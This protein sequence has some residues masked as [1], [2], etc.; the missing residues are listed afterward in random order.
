[1]WLPLIAVLLP[2][3]AAAVEPGSVDAHGRNYA[4]R[5][6]WNG[7]PAAWATV[8]LA[9]PLAS[10]TEMRVQIRTNRFVD[11][12]WSLRAESWGE[13]DG[14]TLRP[15]RFGYDRRVNGER[16]LTTVDA[17]ASGLLTGRYARAGRYRLVEVNDTAVLDPIAAILQALREPPIIGQPK[18]YEIFTGEARY[19]IVLRREGTETIRVPAGRFTA[20]RIEPAIWRLENNQPDR[21]VRRV[22]LW[23]T[24]AAPHILLRVRGDV[25]IGAVYCDLIEQSHDDGAPRAP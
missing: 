9:R 16:E 21:R 24:D 7:I 2:G 12:F 13:V 22:T 6:S 20:A 23:I 4:Y 25:F 10:R 14:I 17:E 1:M 3:L 18:S 11:L 5:I 8:R 15:L 19:R